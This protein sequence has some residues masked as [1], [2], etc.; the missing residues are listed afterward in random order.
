[1][2]PLFVVLLAIR[3]A[4]EERALTYVPA[5]WNPVRRQ[6][7]ASTPESTVFPVHIGSLREPGS[8]E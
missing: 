8:P 7:H 1:M 5:K 6:G 2:A 3:A 4:I